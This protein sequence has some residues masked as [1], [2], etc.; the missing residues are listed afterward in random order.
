MTHSSST[1]RHDYHHDHDHRDHR[2]GHMDHGHP[3]DAHS[4]GV[5]HWLASL[6]GGHSHDA[7]DQIDDALEANSAGRRALVLSMLGLV[8]T[9]LV[10]G[11]VVWAS[12]SVA[13]LGDTLHNV[14]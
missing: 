13:L 14:A 3:H 6:V 9:A 5:R 8:A 1:H 10:Q 11:V 12:G 4:R 7:A 2:H